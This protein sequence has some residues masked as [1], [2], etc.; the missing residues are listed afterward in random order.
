MD[1]FRFARHL[2]EDYGK[3]VP[4]V[5]QRSA[6]HYFKGSLRGAAKERVD[7]SFGALVLG[8]IRQQEQASFLVVTFPGGEE[9]V[10]RGQG[11]NVISANGSGSGFVLLR[12]GERGARECNCNY[13]AQNRARFPRRQ[14]S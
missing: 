1:L 11:R 7:A 12:P 3:L 5:A 8:S 14:R 9:A 6:L 13:G 4:I 10:G 2:Q